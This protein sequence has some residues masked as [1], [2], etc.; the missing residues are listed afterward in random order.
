MYLYIHIN[1]CIYIYISIRRRGGLLHVSVLPRPTIIPNPPLDFDLKGCM[2]CENQS[3]RELCPSLWV[4]EPDM[5]R[6]TTEHPEP[7]F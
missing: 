1:T 3:L 2:Q 7:A 4:V 6:Q 5:A